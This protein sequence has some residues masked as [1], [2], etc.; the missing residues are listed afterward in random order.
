MSRTNKSDVRAAVDRAHSSESERL[1]PETERTLQREL[2]R[3]WAKIQGQPNSYTMDKLEFSVFN[4][5]RSE[6]RFQNETARKAV[7]R[8]WSSTFGADGH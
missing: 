3:V 7:E 2:D 8:Y 4:R 5:Y 1:D 6:H